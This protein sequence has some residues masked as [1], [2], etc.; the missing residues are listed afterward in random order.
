MG[1]WRFVLRGAAK[2]GA[3]RWLKGTRPGFPGELSHVPAWLE[4]SPPKKKKKQSNKTPLQFS[5]QKGNDLFG[6][7]GDG[8]DFCSCF[9]HRR[10]KGRLTANG[11]TDNRK[12]MEARNPSLVPACGFGV[13]LG[14]FSGNQGLLFQ[15]TPQVKRNRP[16]G[17]SCPQKYNHEIRTPAIWRYAFHGNKS[18]YLN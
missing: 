3:V 10:L 7:G 14:R 16:D 4:P 8:K 2:S 6:G 5:Q 12:Q 11:A 13:P 15:F 1:I 9:G 17:Q 18:P